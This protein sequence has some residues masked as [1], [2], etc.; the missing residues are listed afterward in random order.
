MPSDGNTHAHRFGGR[1]ALVQQACPGKRQAG[2]ICNH[3]LKVQQC[4]QTPLRDLGLIGRVLRVPTGVLQ[5]V[6]ENHRRRDSAGV[7]HADA[8]S[9]DLI[10]AGDRLQAL[11]KLG[12]ATRFGDVQR[13]V[14]P[15]VGGHGRIG[16]RIQR[17]DVA[18]MEQLAHDVIRLDLKL[19]DTERLQ[20]L[21]G[22]YVD[23]LLKD[24]Q[25][26]AFSLANAPHDDRYL[27]LHVRH[28]E[29]GTF[30][31][32]VFSRMQEK[33][34]LRI[35]GPLGSF[36]LRENSER[37]MIFVAGGTGFAPIKGIVQHALAEG[38]TRPIYLYWGV[39]AKRDLY[40][41]ELPRE[42]AEEYSHVSYSPVLSEPAPEDAW[43]GRTGLV[44]E[45]VSADFPEL[46]S[47]E[48]YASGPPA[49]IKAARE[50]FLAQGLSPDNLFSDSF[51]FAHET[52]KE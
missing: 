7:T 21:A 29:G 30:T 12:F 18:R 44:H 10:L 39:R 15:N 51:E 17:R 24:G 25:R 1:G 31:D 49:M 20:F 52:G 26:R 11:Q 32:F 8:R 28:I 43:P 38:V 40:M 13:C 2:Q 35:E 41:D 23:V 5:N 22:Q 45:A 42:W 4:F 14:E 36:V 46:H 6:T 3:G 37:P 47:Y 19:P 34:L 16:K 50:A 33:A 48:V 27:E 9:I